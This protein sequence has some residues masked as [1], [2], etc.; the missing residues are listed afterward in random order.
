[1]SDPVT[2]SELSGQWVTLLLTVNSVVNGWPCYWQ[3]TQ[4]LMSDPVTDGERLM[5]DPVSD[6][7]LRG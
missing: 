7:E 3:W 5:S 2:D 6:S 4:W 1:M